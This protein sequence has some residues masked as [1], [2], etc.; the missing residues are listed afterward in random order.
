V[1]TGSRGKNVERFE[2]NV[3]KG[4]ISSAKYQLLKVDDHVT[5]NCDI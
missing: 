3:Y 2:I 1:Q 5:G 4:K